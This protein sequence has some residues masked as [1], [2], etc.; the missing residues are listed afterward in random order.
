MKETLDTRITIRMKS[1]HKAFLEVLAEAL[2]TNPS[3][4]VRY[5]LNEAGKNFGE[6][7]VIE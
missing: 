4:A 6:E 2:N 3:G 1:K 7:S 5:I